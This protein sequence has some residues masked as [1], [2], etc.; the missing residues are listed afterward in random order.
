MTS[1]RIHVKLPGAVRSASPGRASLSGAALLGALFLASVP[2]SAQDGETAM[3]ASARHVLEEH[4]SRCHQDGLLKEGLDRPQGKFGFILDLDRVVKKRLVIP[5]NSSGSTLMRQIENGSMPKDMSS[6]CYLFPPPDDAYCGPSAEEVA[7]LRGWIDSLSNPD[8]ELAV[9]TAPEAATEP[10]AAAD[11]GSGS[12]D[13]ASGPAEAIAEETDATAESEAAEQGGSSLADAIAE[14]ASAE[15]DATAEP[16]A[17]DEG[18]TSLA[19]AI[20]E[21]ASAEADASLAE[22]ATA[23]AEAAAGPGFLRD[24]DMIRVMALDLAEV[25]EAR[26]ESQRYLTL[27]HL[28]NAGDEE[29][30]LDVYRMA[31]GKLL[32]SLSRKADPVIPVVVDDAKV[33]LRFDITDLGWAPSLW[34]KL[35]EANPYLLNYDTALYDTLMTTT[36]TEMPFVRADWF[37]F[38]ASQPPLY[39][40]LLGLPDT[41]QELEKLL[42]VDVLANL[43]ALD[44]ARAGFRHSGVSTNNRLI[45][46]HDMATGSYWESYDFAGN[47]GRQDFFNF[48]LGPRSAFDGMGEEHGFDADGGEIIFTLPNGF[49]AYYLA[50]G[51]GK[52]LDKGPTIIVRDDSRRDA[53]VTNGISCMGCHDRGVKFNPHRPREAH[54]EI[55]EVVLA[56]ISVDKEV[57]ETVAEVYPTHERF[58]ELMQADAE[59][60]ERSLKRAGIDM[61]VKYDGMEMVNALFA[62]FEEDVTAVL[63]AAEYGLT[64]EEFFTRLGIA[65]GSA[66]TLKIRLAQD[67]IPRDQFVKEYA[68]LAEQITD[69]E[70]VSFAAVAEA[71]KDAVKQSEA[72]PAEASKTFDLS[73][74]PT[75]E[76]YFVGDEVTFTVKSSQPCFLTLLNVDDT[77][78]VQIAFPNKFNT[79]NE[80]EADREYTIPS[81]EIGGFKFLF[82]KPGKEKVI[83]I[84]NASRSTPRGIV[85]DF[86]REAYTTF[87]SIGDF[88][89]SRLISVVQDSK[90]IKSG[91]ESSAEA[92]IANTI[93]PEV[94]IVAQKAVVLDVQDKQEAAAQ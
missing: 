10:G 75:T 78:A 18:G 94:D 35:S 60:Y 53:S 71:S 77:D 64:E 52:Q 68:A 92:L 21:Q 40:T 55:R 25:P 47:A 43:E 22:S 66:Y 70:A 26:R 56:N 5:G 16:D 49:H 65:G 15:A 32:N 41:K 6:D 88:T 20:A 12:G 36:G 79:G 89:R 8:L 81:A 90:A 50:T 82:S 24:E 7:A 11:G 72:R 4:C 3:T 86:D 80:I 76:K 29:E 39:H 87:R 1:K 9:A 48:P 54:D 42:G 28:K 91:T 69:Y 93:D 13:G 84:C 17:G 59:D 30:A 27:W 44:V 19:D 34:D 23:P 83:A 85:H 74:V 63:A 46:R 33:I 37:A 61:N 51:E 67:R 31:V 58:Y 2:A 45:E 14:Q 73:L 62:R 57:R 38:V